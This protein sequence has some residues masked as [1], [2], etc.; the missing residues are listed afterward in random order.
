MRSARH[1]SDPPSALQN[2]LIIVLWFLYFLV[3][4][5]LGR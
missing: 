3:A 4:W 5:T 1:P 2:A